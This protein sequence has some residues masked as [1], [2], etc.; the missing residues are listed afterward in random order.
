VGEAL[1]DALDDLRLVIDSLDPGEQDLL[2][3]L[4]MVRA[5]LEPRLAQHGLRFQWR[6]VEVPPL[7]GFGPD[8]ALQ[9]MRIV[10]EA[11]TNVVKHARASRITIRTGEAPGPGG[12]A[13]VF[14]EIVDDGN[15]MAAHPV[16]GRGLVG[17]RRRAARLGGVVAIDAMDR[18][19]RVR[20]WLPQ[21]VASRPD[22]SRPS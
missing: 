19:T 18:G 12:R 14:V 6:V 3:V 4:G 15:G 13:G 5:R 2:T 16:P 21:A 9:V 10:Q 11:I 22:V 8:M 7:P 1:R 20:L 17:M